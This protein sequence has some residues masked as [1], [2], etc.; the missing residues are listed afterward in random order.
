VSIPAEDRHG[1]ITFPSGQATAS[2][3]RT[4]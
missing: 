2:H 4:R 1:G 3:D